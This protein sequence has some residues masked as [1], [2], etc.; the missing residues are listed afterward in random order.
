MAA[1]AVADG[2]AV[3]LD[4]LEEALAAQGVLHCVAGGVAGQ[5]GEA[6]AVLV[7][8]GRLGEDVDGRQVGPGGDLEVVGV[9]GGGDFD[10]A[11]PELGVDRGVGH[12]RDLPADER[13]DERPADGGGVALVVGVDGHAGVAE[14]RLGPGGGH[15]DRPVTVGERIPDV[16]ELA[17]DVL[18]L[19]LD[20][21]QGRMA[22][23]APVDD[24]VGPVDE[25]LFV[26]PHEDDADRPGAA[27]VHREPLAGPVAGGTHLP[28]LLG[29]APALFG[30]PLPHP[31]DEGVAAD[32]VAVEAFLGQLPLHDVLGGDAGVVGAGQPQSGVA[33]HPLAADG[34]V[35]QRVL[36]GVAHV[37]R[38]G[39]VGRRDHDAER[40]AA[41]V[42][43]GP[44]RP[45]LLPDRVPAP[46]DRLG[47]VGLGHVGG[48]RVHH[49]WR[50]VR[51]P[52][53]RSPPRTPQN[54]EERAEASSR[55]N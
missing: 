8:H 39:D 53:G 2:V 54:R 26:E 27:L 23:G 49:W 34:G 42:D 3:L 24:P 10:G 31:L 46:L 33:L 41:L 29:D 9:V 16:D 40:L 32:L 36:E 43:L 55:R 35:D 13:Q 48:G 30:L 21:G 11:R 38:A 52:G 5:S 20:V 22:A 44:E 28:H 51:A 37:E 19:D 50:S 6:A 14:H 17:V 18:V 15:A 47:V 1:V 45:R 25:A 12:H 4:A 7:D